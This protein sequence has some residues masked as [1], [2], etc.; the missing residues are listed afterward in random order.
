VADSIV[1]RAVRLRE[2]VPL[3]REPDERA[4]KSP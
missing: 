3:V 2:Q 4:P 1:R